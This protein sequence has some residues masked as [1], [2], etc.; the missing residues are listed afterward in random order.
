MQT[1]APR[2]YWFKTRDDYGRTNYEFKVGN[3]TAGVVVRLPRVAIENRTD[4]A[5]YFANDWRIEGDPLTTPGKLTYHR[6]LNAAKAEL[7]RR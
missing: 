5:K 2:T 7:E 1:D 4:G 3:R 6:T